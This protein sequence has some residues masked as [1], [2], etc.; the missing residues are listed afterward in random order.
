M[1]SVTR[2][3]VAAIAFGLLSAWTLARYDTTEAD[4]LYVTIGRDAVLIAGAF[5]IVIAV[6]THARG[7]KIAGGA[8]TSGYL[9]QARL[10]RHAGFWNL[11]ALRTA[12]PLA[13]ELTLTNKQYV[14]TPLGFQPAG[15]GSTVPGYPPGLP[16]HFALAS[17]LGGEPAQFVVV[18]LLTGGLVMVAFLI[19]FRIGGPVTGLLSAAATGSSPI[20]LY[21]AAQ[22]MSDVVATFWWSLSVLL[23]ISPTKRRLTGAGIAALIACAVRPNLF[24]MTPVLAM[25]IWWWRGW[26]RASIA[27]LISFLTPIALAAAVFAALQT[28]LYGNAST[29]GYGQV[30]SLFSLG[31]VMPNLVRYPRWAI[32]T[33]SAILLAAVVA[34][35]AIR[36]GWIKPSIDALIAER[37]AWSGLLFFVCLQAFYLLYIPFD[38]WVFFRF[39]LPALPW[40]LCLQSAAMAA[41]IR[42]VPLSMRGTAVLM[43][44]ILIASWGVGRARG[45]GAFRLQESEQRYLDVAEFVRG[46]PPNAVFITLQHSG[47]LAYYDAASVLRWDWLEP[48]ELDRAVVSLSS[49]GHPVFVVLEDHEEA[50][51]RT[52]FAA[53]SVVERLKDPV[54]VAGQ[55]FGIIVR[56]FAIRGAL[57]IA[58]DPSFGSD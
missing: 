4:R 14:F 25:M 22:P 13:R 35:I 58:A 18:P 34:P 39:L 54:Y 24:A 29:T 32:F 50:R 17:T 23:V 37:I 52:R 56:V 53:S 7:M 2:P 43:V 6:A 33:Q 49:N 27:P 26:T 11:E 41:A 51:F 55:P 10:W 5:A 31:H 21:Q 9:S 12:T 30:G 8:D 28:N 57:T 15:N 19:G 47:S 48:D 20:V 45:L 42:R 3:V 44:A 38:D 40:L 16:L 46:L 36:R 1:H